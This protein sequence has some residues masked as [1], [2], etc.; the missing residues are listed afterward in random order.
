MKGYGLMRNKDDYFED[1][2]DQAPVESAYMLHE[3]QADT[4]RHA[5]SGRGNRGARKH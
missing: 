1:P 5:S 4:L 2:T 3:A